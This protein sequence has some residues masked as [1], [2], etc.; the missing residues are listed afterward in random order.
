MVPPSI[1]TFEFSVI[2]PFQYLREICNQNSSHGVFETRVL[3]CLL[4]KLPP[5]VLP[6]ISSVM[7]SGSLS[8][9]SYSTLSFCVRFSLWSGSCSCIGVC[10]WN[11][12]IPGLR[13][14]DVSWGLADLLLVGAGYILSLS[15]W[16]HEMRP[17][18]LQ[19]GLFSRLSLG[20][21]RCGPTGPRVGV[22]YSSE[23]VDC[24]MA[25]RQYC[26]SRDV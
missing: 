7:P 15:F 22:V 25:S 9:S 13:P 26:H 19:S 3:F 17:Y 18:V 12:V 5:T 24:E 14:G 8:F 23:W 16:P 21:M 6:A 1:C 20:R 11:G 2:F 10:F 4:N